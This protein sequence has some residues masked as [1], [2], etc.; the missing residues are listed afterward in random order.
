MAIERNSRWCSLA[1]G[2]DIKSIYLSTYTRMLF[3]QLFE[4]TTLSTVRPPIMSLLVT[5]ETALYTV[6][7]I[8]INM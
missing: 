5:N 4:S 8:F 6:H 2:H 1:V 7:Y 3:D